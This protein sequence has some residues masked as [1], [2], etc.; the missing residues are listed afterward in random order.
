MGETKELVAIN[1][2]SLSGTFRM[3]HEHEIRAFFLTGPKA[4]TL[5]SSEE[6][7]SVC[8]SERLVN[9]MHCLFMYLEGS[10]K[11]NKDV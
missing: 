6:Q 9:L 3:S 2:P 10:L 4:M 11:Y 1:H 5:Q 7:T 8:R